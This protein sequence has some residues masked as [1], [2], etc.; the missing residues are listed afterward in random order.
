MFAVKGWSVDASALKAQVAPVQ[1]SEK[2]SKEAARKD[3]KRKRGIGGPTPPP[4]EDVGQLWEQYIE[5]KEPVKAQDAG[6]KEK[7]RARVENPDA[8][9]HDQE[10]HSKAKKPEVARESERN[11][12]V[13]RNPKTEKRNKKKKEKKASSSVEGGQ[14]EAKTAQRTSKVAAAA[15]PPAPPVPTAARLT[16]MQAAMRQKLVSARFRHLNQTLYTAPSATALELFDQNPEMFEDYHAGFRQQVN[17]WPENP[18]DN[19]IATIRSRGE[20]KPPGFKDKKGKKAPEASETSS[21][22]LTLPRTHGTAIIADLGCGDARLAQTL[23]S[24]SDTS[25]LNLKIHSYDLHSPSPLVTKADISNLPLA[26]NSAD[27]A[28]FCLALMGTNWIAFIEEAYRIL[29]WR[30]ELWVAEIK[31]RFGRVGRAGKVVEHSV[32]S[33]KKQAATQ[34]AQATKQKEDAEVDEQALLRTAVDGVEA[35]QEATDVSAFVDVLRRRGFVLKEGEKGVDLGN[36]MFVK[37]EFVKAATPT[38][39]K[40]IV[41]AEQRAKIGQA[42]KFVEKPT[43]DVAT[44]DESK[45]LKP[46]LYKI[47]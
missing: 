31:S 25:K 10:T 33:K 5:G 11:E 34:K 43:E 30:G 37:M 26:D 14:A 16:P 17:V 7:K 9:K 18:L 19:F 32:G 13:A 47:R 46:C 27:V 28:I 45:M 29:H 2:A 24:S 6:R 40:G 15:P 3:R 22:V 21:A 8:H 23:Q 41:V 12:G 20:V 4:K 35:K 39:G 44:D 42:K 36:K 1:D 38:K